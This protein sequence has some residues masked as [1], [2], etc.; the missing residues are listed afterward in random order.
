MGDEQVV[1]SAINQAITDIAESG[2]DISSTL[3][4]AEDIIN[5]KIM[6]TNQ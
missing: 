3:K 5:A 1:T 4:N 2:R 6:E